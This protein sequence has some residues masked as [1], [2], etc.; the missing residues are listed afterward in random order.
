MVHK[1]QV[2]VR[3]RVELAERVGHLWCIMN[4]TAAQDAVEACHAQLGARLR[5]V[6]GVIY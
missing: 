5:V 4:I 2:F 6:H 1:G 3:Q